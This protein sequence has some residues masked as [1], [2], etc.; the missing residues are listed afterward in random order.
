MAVVDAVTVSLIYSVWQQYTILY[1]CM[2]ASN[3]IR[4]ENEN[5]SEYNQKVV[6]FY[7]RIVDCV[8]QLDDIFS[9]LMFYEFLST[10][11]YVCG[12]LGVV[13]TRTS[14]PKDIGVGVRGEEFSWLTVFKYSTNW[15]LTLIRL[16]IVI[17]WSGDLSAKVTNLK[18]RKIYED[19]K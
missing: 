16:L 6:E 3:Q 15:I 11:P 7:L 4:S 5:T 8:R 13:I 12:Q 2:S 9:D 14:S 18:S 10:L 17:W 1:K 19:V